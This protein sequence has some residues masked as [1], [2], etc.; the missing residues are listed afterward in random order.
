VDQL[1]LELAEHVLAAGRTQVTFFV[2]VYLHITIHSRAKHISS[3]IKLSTMDEQWIVDIL[4]DY[5]SSTAVRRRVLYDALDLIKV[6]GN[7]D[8]M[9]S[10]RI[11]TWFDDPNVLWWCW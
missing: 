5:A 9:A 6:S 10:V 7:L 2:N 11:L 8:T 4:L 3:N 1:V